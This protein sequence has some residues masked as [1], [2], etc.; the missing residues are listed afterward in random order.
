MIATETECHKCR[1]RLEKKDLGNIKVNF[2]PE[3]GGF[4]PVADR[5]YT[6][7]SSRR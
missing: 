3:C 1:G 6:M 2:C 5:P 4:E 7:K